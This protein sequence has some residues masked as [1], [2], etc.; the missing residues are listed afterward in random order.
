VEGPN[1]FAS[2]Q[3]VVG[4]RIRR[5]LEERREIREARLQPKDAKFA[6]FPDLMIIDGGKGQLSAVQEVLDQFG[7]T[8]PVFGLAKEFEHLFRPKEGSPI[9]LKPNSPAFYLIQ[10]MRDEAHRFAI[11]Y[12]RKLRSKEQVKSVL[13]DIPGIGPARRK[14]L[15]RAYGS[16]EKIAQAGRE[17]L[18]LVKGMNSAAAKQVYE[19][20]HKKKE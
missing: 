9:I 6:D 15:L 10:R 17:E 18:A 8:L 16:V 4:R 13:D 1:D 11:T 12:H 20:F 7:L 14:A 19:F 5:G 3:E 2:L